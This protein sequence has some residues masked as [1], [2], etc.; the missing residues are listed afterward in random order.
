M[1]LKDTKYMM[2]NGY[3]NIPG[4][5]ATILAKR[6]PI[7]RNLVH[8]DQ[9]ARGY[10][11]ANRNANGYEAALMEHR[12][13]DIDAILKLGEQNIQWSNHDGKPSQHCLTIFHKF[14][15]FYI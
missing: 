7:Y 2:Q 10:N 3:E 15:Q 14:M 9:I 5:A 8:L 6:D 12:I 4:A 11:K 1:V 13:G